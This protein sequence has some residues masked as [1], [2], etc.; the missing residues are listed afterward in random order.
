MTHASDRATRILA[1]ANAPAAS[2]AASGRYRRSE[3]FRPGER[4]WATSTSRSREDWFGIQLFG[5]AVSLRDRLAAPLRQRG[6]TVRNDQTGQITFCKAVPFGHGEAIDVPR[7]K[8]V[9]AEIDLVLGQIESEASPET[10]R[11]GAD[12]IRF[13]Q[14]SPMMGLEL[15][16]PERRTDPEPEGI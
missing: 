3:P 7:V 8:A 4:Y 6:F 12:F 10:R 1:A 16:L 15:E 14:A 2:G 9:R 5:P 13:M 11:T